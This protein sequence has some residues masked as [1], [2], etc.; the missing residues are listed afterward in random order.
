M[1][2]V[3]RTT[4]VALVIAAA[5]TPA[6]SAGVTDPPVTGSA[7]QHGLAAPPEISRF[8]EMVA[9]DKASRNRALQRAE[10]APV[11]ALVRS[12]GDGFDWT[13][14]A[15][16]ATVPLALLLLDLLARPAVTRRRSRLAGV[17]S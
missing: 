4:A 3:K 10:N 8:D 6:A 17:A 12:D 14:A 11:K 7:Q 5:A 15:I 9:L 13:S 16:G 2:Q 1:L